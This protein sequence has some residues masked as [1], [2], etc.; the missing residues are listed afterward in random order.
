MLVLNMSHL[1]ICDKWHEFCVNF[2]GWCHFDFWRQEEHITFEWRFLHQGRLHFGHTD[3]VWFEHSKHFVL[4][5]E[6]SLHTLRIV[7]GWSD[8]ALFSSQSNIRFSIFDKSRIFFSKTRKLRNF[9]VWISQWK[10][11]PRHFSRSTCFTQH[12]IWQTEHFDF[13]IFGQ[14]IHFP[15]RILGWF[16]E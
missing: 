9:L 8:S 2:T 12:R 11:Y 1:I 5:F 15:R 4:R 10:S 7:S 13:V 6:P 16:S 14:S 3:R